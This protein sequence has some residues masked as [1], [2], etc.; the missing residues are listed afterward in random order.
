MAFSR[1][2]APFP[3]FAAAVLLAAASCATFNPP[4]EGAARAFFEVPGDCAPVWTPIAR[5]LDFASFS[6]RRPPLEVN[7]LRAD[8]SAPGLSVVVAGRQIAPATTLSRKTTSFL[9][10]YGCA[11]AV[12]ATPFAPSSAKEGERRVLAGLCVADGVAI[13]PPD[14]RYA[15]LVFRGGR[16]SVEAQGDIVSLEDIDDAVGGFFVVLSGGEPSGHP[17]RR[18]ARTAAGVGNGGRTLFLLTIDARRLSS[19]GATEPETGLLL[20]R[21]GA[22]DGLIL[23]G[24]GSTAMAIRRPDGG[25]ALANVPTHGFLPG[26]ERAVGNALGI[27]A[28]PR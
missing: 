21:L 19:A 23:D 3:V 8:L 13:S 22:V 14:G 2:T 25:A 17:T 9:A 12:N 26:N 28:D 16:A 10:E 6:V 4:A 7:A 11:A 20:A 5:G 24:G 18:Y 1:R 15:A 27:R